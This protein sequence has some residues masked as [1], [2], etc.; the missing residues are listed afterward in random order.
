MSQH[1]ALSGIDPD[2]TL[3][4]NRRRALIAGGVTIA[5]AIWQAIAGIK[6]P[7]TA[8]LPLFG[9]FAQLAV[10][11]VLGFCALFA[12]AYSVLWVGRRLAIW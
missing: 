7:L 6:G 12:A 2:Q 3:T 4:P 5:L 8:L 11:A 9:F 10:I 1:L